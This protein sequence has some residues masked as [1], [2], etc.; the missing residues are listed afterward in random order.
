MLINLSNHPTSQ[1]S[2]K[3]LNT[4]LKKYKSVFDLPFPQIPPRASEEQV[5]KI[6][7][8]YV[9]KCKAIISKSSDKHNAVHIMGELTF[10]FAV[11]SKLIKAGVKCVAST[12]TR[13][14]TQV[15][16]SKIS[17]FEFVKFREY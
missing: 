4:A 15:N 8:S 7:N 1:W 10:C 9:K 17:K 5:E 14:A 12:T 2:T 3:Q 13:N 11:I 16:D 6:G